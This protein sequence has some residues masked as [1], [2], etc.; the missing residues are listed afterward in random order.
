[1]S[2]QGNPTLA[3]SNPSSSMFNKMINNTDISSLLKGW[4][5]LP[6]AKKIGLASGVVL[7][8]SIGIGVILW[9]QDETYA[10][11][12][13][14]IGQSDVASIRQV[15]DELGVDYKIDTDS[16]LLMVPV[17][18][19]NELKLQLARQGLPRTKSTYVDG[20][21]VR[22]IEGKNNESMYN[23]RALEAEI[24]KTVTSIQQVKSA[25]VLL[26]LPRQSDSD[27]TSQ[28]PSASIVVKLYQGHQLR[29]GQ[30]QAII[31][32]VAASVPTLESTDVTIVDQN[33]RMLSSHDVSGEMSLSSNQF[34][35][36]KNIEEHLIQ[37]IENILIPLVGRGGVT[38]QV[39]AKVDF[40]ITERTQEMFY[41]DSPALRS[42]QIQGS[43]NSFVDIKGVSSSVFNEPLTTV[44]VAS[45]LGKTATRNYELDK[46]VTHTRLATGV[47]SRLSVAVVVDDKNMNSHSYSKADVDKFRELV[48]QAVG[49]DEA[50]GD[51]VTVSNISF[52]APEK[53]ASL[54][55]PPLWQQAQFMSV[56]K[57]VIAFTAV[58]FLILGVIRP[59]VRRLIAK[60]DEVKSL[61]EAHAEA[62]SIGGVVQIGH[63]GKP[64]AMLVSDFTQEPEDLLMLETPQSYS[65]RLDYVQKLIDENPLQV[66]QIMSGWLKSNG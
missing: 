14:G 34:E 35:Y 19:A 52:K 23:Q 49:F 58:L 6:M 5:S 57:Q 64:V 11:L 27:K 38:V 31:H 7:S 55:E 20:G 2:K 62:D 61:L 15:I 10:L 26:A 25:R 32:L 29:K 54:P 65:K 50:R 60:D 4:N 51:L 12:Y 59:M 28:K 43:K 53:I 24:V 16:G 45:P 56:I 40:T 22:L 21:V 44:G 30:V 13:D 8:V 46:T 63:D 48:M 36:K 42:E 37:R 9:S 66:S 47:I 41:P 3:E 18:K 33:G 1:M 17:D 39:S